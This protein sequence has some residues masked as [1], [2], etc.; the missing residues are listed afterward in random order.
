MQLSEAEW[1][2]MNAIWA[3]AP[4]SARDVLEHLGDETTWAYTTVKTMLARLAE[5]GA[6]SVRKR[7]NTSMYEPLISREEARRSAVKGL[8]ERAF[9]GSFAPLVQFLVSDRD[10]SPADRKTLEKLIAESGDK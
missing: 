9:G 6:L 3:E 5:K 7:A 10:L 2:V 1:K 4:S 8:L